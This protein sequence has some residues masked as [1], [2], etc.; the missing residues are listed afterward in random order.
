MIKKINKNV[1]KINK[2]K[3]VSN[4]MTRKIDVNAKGYFSIKAR[5]ESERKIIGDLKQLCLQDQVE[6]SDLVFEGLILMF[7]D[8]NWPPGNPQLQLSV[9]QQ[10]TLHPILEKCKCG[11]TSTI[12]TTDL[13]GI[14]KVERYF[15]KTCFRNVPG[16]YD[17]KLWKI[18]TK[19][20]E[21][22]M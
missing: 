22:K 19:I 7:K 13:R 11:R 2:K 8:H 18:H 9:F 16:R 10:N 5:N 1:S 15:C 21:A 12:H 3:C 17:P 20:T 4:S 14:A 6:I